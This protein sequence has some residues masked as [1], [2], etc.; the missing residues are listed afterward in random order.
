MK[1]SRKKYQPGNNPYNNPF[2]TEIS[3][4]RTSEGGMARMG[5]SSDTYGHGYGSET[6]RV[7]GTKGSFYDKYQGLEKNLP[8][9]T[10]PPLPPGVP[11][12]GHGGSHGRLSDE[13]ISAILEDRLP[14]VHIANALNMTVGGIIAHRSALRDG[15]WLDIPQYSL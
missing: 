12:G 11:A 6:G 10:Q 13:F 3:L 2:Q 8:D 15:E 9:I 5:R 4:Y 1:S 14:E 7:R